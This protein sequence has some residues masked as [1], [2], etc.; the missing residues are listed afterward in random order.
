MAEQ[1]VLAPVRCGTRRRLQIYSR[2]YATTCVSFKF[3]GQ[4]FKGVDFLMLNAQW[5]VFLI[6]L[7]DLVKIGD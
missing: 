3:Q 2:N 4:K 5:S 6:D 1:S 7:E